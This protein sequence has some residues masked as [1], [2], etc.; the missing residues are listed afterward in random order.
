MCFLCLSAAQLFQRRSS[1]GSVIQ[2]LVQQFGINRSLREQV[3]DA[4]ARVS[5]PKRIRAVLNSLSDFRVVNDRLDL[6]DDRASIAVHKENVVGVMTRFLTRADVDRRQM[7][8]RRFEQ[9]EARVSQQ[10]RRAAQQVYKLNVRNILKRL[11][12]RV[13][14]KLSDR[15]DDLPAARIGV[16]I[17]D[18]R[19]H[20]ELRGRRQRFLHLRARV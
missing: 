15:R 20:A 6:P 1:S 5:I 4:L 2:V 9:S 11:E 17:T 19:L 13:R 10:R 14:L 8:E 7:K 12:T 16:W 18:E 3:G